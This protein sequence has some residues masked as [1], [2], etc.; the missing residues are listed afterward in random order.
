MTHQTE[1]GFWKCD[2]IPSDYG[3][4]IRA[5]ESSIVPHI[6][7]TTVCPIDLGFPEGPTT[8]AVAHLRIE[9]AKTLRDNLTYLI[10]LYNNEE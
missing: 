10:N 4:Y 8:R 2:P 7:V 3:G 5:Y 9:D 6:W 1:R